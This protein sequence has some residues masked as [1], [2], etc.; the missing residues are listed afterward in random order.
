MPKI[1]PKPEVL[2]GLIRLV[3]EA[4]SRL[5]RHLDACPLCRE[6]Q[7]GKRGLVRRDN[8]LP[9]PAAATE[10]GRAVD[11]VLAG[12]RPRLQAAVRESAE[13]PLLLSEL[14]EHRPERRELLVRNSER[15]RNLPLCRMLLQRGYR[16]TFDAP[17][18][19]ERLATLAL[20][21]VDTLDAAWYGE[22][23]LD[24]ARARCW[25]VIANARRVACDLQG[26]EE[27]FQ[28]AVSLLERGTGDPL[29]KAQLLFYKACLR[30]AQRRLG[31]AAGLY[32][33]SASLFLSSE[34]RQRAA[35]SI[36]GLALTEQYR[37]EPERA[38]RLLKTAMGLV[39]RREESR[40]YH[41]L[42]FNRL[43]FLVEAGRAREARRL[44]ERTPGL[45]GYPDEVLRLRMLWL[46]ARIAL[47][48]GELPRGRGMLALA[49]RG[50][51]RRGDVY[52]AALLSLEL[53]V[54]CGRPGHALRAGLLARQAGALFRSLGIE[55]ESLAA[56]LVLAR[57]FVRAEDGAVNAA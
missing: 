32:R 50:F 38:I 27:A 20:E 37:G 44:L 57:A 24:D 14:L 18:Q 46:E 48:L 28:T 31:E 36:A 13:A 3:P 23:L 26:A 9:W 42:C 12:L 29:E 55:R 7:G 8:L 40:F 19:G 21:M 47:G 51:I 41:A 39:D 4:E 49:R 45:Y 30:R 22:R 11:L 15:F 6:R 34:D 25:M 10:H 43:L 53:A 54:A 5:L 17:R 52:N 56:L 1:H 33:R 16:D 35:E 2:N